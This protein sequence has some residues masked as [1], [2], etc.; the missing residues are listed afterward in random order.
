M[1]SDGGPEQPESTE[2]TR[3][4][5]GGMEALAGYVPNGTRS[6][7]GSGIRHRRSER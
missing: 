4:P 6:L 5:K 3:V 2:M 1:V 7:E